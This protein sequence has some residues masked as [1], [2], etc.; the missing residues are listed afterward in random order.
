MAK[1]ISGYIIHALRT[2]P[3]SGKLEIRQFTVA[4]SDLD[5]A[6]AALFKTHPE[7]QSGY[8]VE[9]GMTLYDLPPGLGNGKIWEHEV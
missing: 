2:A 4:M 9:G 3:E 7:L 8:S 6:I 1:E 5:V